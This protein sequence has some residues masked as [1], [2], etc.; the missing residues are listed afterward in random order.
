VARGDSLILAKALKP[1]QPRY[2]DMPAIGPETITA[3]AEAGIGAIVVQAEGT[4]L[5]ERQRLEERAT[6]RGIA[7]V[8]VR[9]KG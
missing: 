6:A 4:L 3:C 7:I 1:R 9:V 8:G 2:I 5:V